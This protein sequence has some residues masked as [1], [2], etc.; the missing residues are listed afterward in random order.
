MADFSLLDDPAWNALTTEHAALAQRNGRAAL[1]R[2]ELSP[3]GGLQSYD[4]AA[5]AE[6]RPLVGPEE[7]VALVSAS[8]YAVPG[9]WELLQAVPAFQMVCET[10]PAAPGI[11]PVRLTVADAPEMLE[12]ALATEPGP[13][14][15]GTIATG[16]Y[17]GLRSEDGRLMAMAGERMRLNGLTEVS[18]VCTWPE[19]RGRGLAKALV[20]YVAALI[21]AEGR[22]PFLHVKA[23]NVAALSLYERL[24][25][26]VRKTLEFRVMRPR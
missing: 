26:T 19:F 18:A 12:L 4:A 8:Q 23:E 14:R 2:A 9:D 7:A 6:L 13:F 16:R 21:A 20:S 22:V 1:Y 11:E 5:F 25:F 15:I 24:G 17:F 3:L 10:P